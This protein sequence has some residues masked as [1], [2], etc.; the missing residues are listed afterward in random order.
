MFTFIPYLKVILENPSIS[1]AAEKLS[2]SQPA[3]SSALK[4][5]E[6]QLNAPILDRSRKPWVLTEAGKLYYEQG[7][8]Y[9]SLAENLKQQIKDIN[10]IQTGSLTI[11]GS[12]CFN[13]SYLPQALSIFTKKYPGIQISLLDGTVPE[14]VEKTVRGEIDLFLSPGFPKHPQITYEEIFEE[15]IL[16]CVPKGYLV[17]EKYKHLQIPLDVILHGQITEDMDAYGKLDLNE[18]AEYPFILLKESQQMGQI[19]RQLMEQSEISA[20]RIMN[21]NQMVTSLSCTNAGLGISMISETAIRCGNFKEYPV[22]YLVDAPLCSRKMYVAYHS[23]KYVSN[24]SR[25]FISILENITFF[26]E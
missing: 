13:T 11:G 16:L 5:A 26:N 19:F 22:F 9:L 25:E 3:L 18:F 1:A 23:Q 2:I 14:M 15:K 6:E 20:K 12:N 21:T 17:N 8:Q 24:A 10:D 7:I 4:K